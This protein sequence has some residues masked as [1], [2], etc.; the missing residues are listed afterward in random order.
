MDLAATDFSI[1]NIAEDPSGKRIVLSG[2]VP[3]LKELKLLE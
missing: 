2:N 3:T 1:R